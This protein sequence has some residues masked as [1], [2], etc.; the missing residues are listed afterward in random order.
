MFDGETFSWLNEIY[1]M[2]LISKPPQRSMLQWAKYNDLT[3]LRHWND[4]ECM[5]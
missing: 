5:G 1:L 3:V 2:V 4:G